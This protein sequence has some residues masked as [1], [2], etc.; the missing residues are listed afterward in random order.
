MCVCVRACVPCG[1]FC[2]QL[3][4]LDQANALLEVE[5]EIKHMTLLAQ[6]NKKLLKDPKAKISKD[7]V[8]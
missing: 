3:R 4:R 5:E 1:Y 7:E 8:Q 6:K 2:T